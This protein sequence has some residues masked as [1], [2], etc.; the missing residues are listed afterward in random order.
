M[1]ALWVDSSAALKVVESAGMMETR[2]V[3]MKAESKEHE[4][5][6]ESVPQVAGD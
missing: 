4:M 2:Q 1:A 5:V 6:G 3:V